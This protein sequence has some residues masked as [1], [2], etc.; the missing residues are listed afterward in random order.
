VHSSIT[1]VLWDERPAG[2]LLQETA[3]G[4]RDLRKTKWRLAKGDEQLQI[5]YASSQPPHHISDEA[6]TELAVCIYQVWHV[7]LLDSQPC[8]VCVLTMG[9]VM[10]EDRT[11]CAVQQRMAADALVQRCNAGKAAP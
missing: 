1:R 10:L 2:L 11:W 3:P 4:W 6:L 5:T 9:K 7:P 8:G